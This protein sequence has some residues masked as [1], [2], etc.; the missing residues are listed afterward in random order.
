MPEVVSKRIEVRILAPVDLVVSKL[1]RFSDQ[2]RGDIELLARRG[3]IDSASVRRR[4]EEAL[5]DYV[6]DP[7]PVRTSID[8]ACRLIDAE[9][10]AKRRK[11]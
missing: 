8:I 7:A 4:A 1:S 2:D 10:P 6:G 11:G 5:A 9:R 3:L